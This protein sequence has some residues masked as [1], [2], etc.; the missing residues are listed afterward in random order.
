DSFRRAA[1]TSKGRLPDEAL[2]WDGVAR[3]ETALGENGRAGEGA[4]RAAALIANRPS[5]LPH[6]EQERLRA[7]SLA[8]NRKWSDAIAALEGLFG[9][10]PERLDVG[11]DLV[12]TLLECGRT[13][14]AETA[15]G[16]LR[17]I[18]PANAGGDP[19]IDLVEA[20]VAFQ[21]SEYQHAAAAASRARDG[22][23]TLHAVALGQRAARVHGEAIGRRDRREESAPELPAIA[24]RDAA[25]GL[26][27]EAAEAR[28]S[29]GSVLV[30]HASREETRR[31]LEAAR[32]GCR[33]SGI[34]RCEITAR[35][36][37]AMLD[38]MQGKLT[39]GIRAGNAAL[40]D[41]RAIGDRWSEGYVL[42]Q[43]QVLYNWADDQASIKP[44]TEPTLAA[45]RDSGNRRLLLTT[46]TNVA[47]VAIEALELEKAEAYI[48]EA[49]ELS[50]RVGIQ[51]ASAGTSRARGYLE[52]TRGDLDLA[53]ESYTSALQRARQAGVPWNVANYL[54]D[55]AWLGVHTHR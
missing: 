12:S 14:A 1:E 48:V 10:Q 51:I 30:Q 31:A 17:Q 35:M 8:A 36:L 4:R 18:V 41:A 33:Q 24:N 7:R 49:E 47:L 5:V 27:A 52:Q 55:L 23:A 50:R 32:A 54:Y 6:H 13:E 40:A 11:I 19:R 44:L 38:G 28:L 26:A 2:A 37:L 22:A 9:E 21:L 16:R 15:L 34:R 45:L 53:R 46:L 3:A 43:L 39:E 29:L 25:L 20:E 42:S